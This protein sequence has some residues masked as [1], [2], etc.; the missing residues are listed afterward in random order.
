[1]SRSRP[2]PP[3]HLITYFIYIFVKELVR[4]RNGLVIPSSNHECSWSPACPKRYWGNY[5]IG[6]MRTKAP[7]CNVTTST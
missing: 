3:R 1:M 5:I 4:V 2:P 7:P 6:Y